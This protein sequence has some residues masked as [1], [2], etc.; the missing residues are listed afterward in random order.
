MSQS[1]E[2]AFHAITSKSA[3]GFDEEAGWLWVTT[4][5]DPAAEYRAVR[6]DVGMWDLSPLNKWDVRGI[7]AVEAVQRVNTND[8][9]RHAR[10]PGPLRRLRG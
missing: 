1:R 8:I 2:T 6:E 7:D 9:A 5:G 4:F 10:R 3:V